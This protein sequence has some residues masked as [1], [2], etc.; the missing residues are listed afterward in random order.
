MN[1]RYS[2]ASI[3]SGWLL[4]ALYLV[5][6]ILNTNLARS[7]RFQPLREELR[8]WHYLLG[9]LIFIAV[10]WR[11]IAW[12]RDG[13]VA[14]PE[15]VPAG[16]HLW[17]RTLAFTAYLLLLVAPL[18]GVI[19]GWA[20]ELTIR[21][22]PLFSLP[23]LMERDRGIWMFTGYFHSGLGFMTLVLSVAGLITMAW[24]WLRHG[25]GALVLFPPGYG[26]QLLATMSVTV[27]AFATFRS[28]APGPRAVAI[29]WAIIA[30]FTMIGWLIHR[31]RTA[32]ARSPNAGA[33]A[34]LGSP[35][36]A[37]SLVALG[38]AGP[39]ALFRVT[40]W[41]M[42]VTV[43]APEGVTSHLVRASHPDALK[44]PSPPTPYEEEVGRETYKWCRFCH[45]VEKN[46]PHLVG[47]NL[48][49]IFGQKAGT[50]P[51]FT[52]SNAMA[53]AGDKGLIWTDE[54]IAWYIADPQKHLPGT[55]M[56]ISSG[57]IPD[58][59]L[60]QAVVNLLRRE[61]MAD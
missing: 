14:P 61:A 21:I 53:A 48:H 23:T 2:A 11:I 51:G 19:Y 55:S 60:Q 15:G 31:R 32:R 58:P 44:P 42:G 30:T 20:D 49:Y 59:K 54:R 29:F 43:A 46:G 27:Y 26:V 36:A 16:L 50:V 7:D 9:T 1:R 8:S 17:G 3:V 57:P 47:P 5:H 35:V 25:R 33:F 22:G 52:Y 37:L 24:G 12:V 13:R 56:I 18:I 39:W 40:P 28:P 4:A 10:I 41:P 34:R 6:Q 45:T 38:A